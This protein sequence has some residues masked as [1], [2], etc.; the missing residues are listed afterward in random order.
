MD[1]LLIHPSETAQWH[2]LIN[3]AQAHSSVH[4]DEELESYLVFLLM[5]FMQE[6][7][8]AS[9]I[10]ALEYLDS[11]Q[12]AGQQRHDILKDVGDKCLLFAGLFPERAL[13]RRVQLSYFIDLGQSA[14]SELSSTEVSL[15]QLFNN[16]CEGFVPLVDVLLATRDLN[17]DIMSLSPLLAEAFWRE[18]GSDYARQIL[19]ATTDDP[20]F[21]L[22]PGKVLTKRSH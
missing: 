13:K 10:L 5:R 3:E 16:L 14:Y 9:S 6:T 12:K 15:A 4:L 20:R 8:V 1:S 11:L 21:S 19:N 7:D 17:G 18:A 2:A 22:P